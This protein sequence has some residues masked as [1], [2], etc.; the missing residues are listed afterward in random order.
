[1]IRTV[2]SL[3]SKDKVWLDKKAHF[4]HITMT[5]VVRRA[6]KHY[7]QCE[8]IHAKKPIESILRETKG[9]W[10]K[11]DGLTYQQKVRT[12]WEDEK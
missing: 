11:E 9:L 5:E 3:D 7:R 2:V 1:M 6:I 4:E 10:A 12:E 8:E